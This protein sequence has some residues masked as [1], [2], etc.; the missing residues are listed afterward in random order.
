M[1]VLADSLRRA[2][3]HTTPAGP[4]PSPQARKA[5]VHTVAGPAVTV[6]L[7]G[8][9]DPVPAFTFNHLA[10]VVGDVVWVMVQ[11]PVILVVGRA[12]TTGPPVEPPGDGPAAT[13]T[14]RSIGPGT[15]QAASGA[16]VDALPR[17]VVTR[18]TRT[19]D[20]P[21]GAAID[22][23]AT[24]TAT[25]AAGRLYRITFTAINVLQQF[26]GDTFILSITAGGTGDYIAQHRSA[27]AWGWPANLQAIVAGNGTS[28]LYR[29]T[30]RRTAGTG[31]GQVQAS[32]TAPAH[33]IIEDIGRP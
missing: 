9:P 30:L 16:T 29:V 7:G 5:V 13:P 11:G 20:T 19:T 8:S 18:T 14:R 21:S 3:G 6:R 25:L 2:T 31:W 33:L 17:G 12:Y 27:G 10:L 1:S 23:V 32:P 22:D 28:T 26:D 15:L 24:R 4:S